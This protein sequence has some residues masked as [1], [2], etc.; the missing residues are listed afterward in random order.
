MSHRRT[1]V[2]AALLT[3]AFIAACDRVDPLSP[4]RS[5]QVA[6]TNPHDSATVDPT[7]SGPN[8]PPANSPPPPDSAA[9][10]YHGTVTLTGRAIVLRRAA[11]GSII[12]TLLYEPVA[13]TAVTVAD[14]LTGATAATAVTGA[15]GSF[16]VRVPVGTY[17]ISGHPPAG[18]GA[19]DGSIIVF[20]G[21]AAVSTVLYLPSAP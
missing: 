20:A 6:K 3:T 12:D 5:S 8:T 7:Q 18:S 11:A 19:T 17:H 16:A 21:Q 9:P 14:N 10:A 13:G 2:V 15:D 4:D 1:L